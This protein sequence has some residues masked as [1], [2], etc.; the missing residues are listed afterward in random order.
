MDVDNKGPFTSESSQQWDV[1]D[2]KQPLYIGGVPDPN[3][4]RP[5]L[6]GASG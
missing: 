4:L 5:E 6:A 2:L 3:Q 1:L